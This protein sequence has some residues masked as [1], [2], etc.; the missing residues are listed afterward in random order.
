MGFSWILLIGSNYGRN[1]LSCDSE[2][3]HLAREADWMHYM[4]TYMC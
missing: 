1:T 2:W 3:G 4:N